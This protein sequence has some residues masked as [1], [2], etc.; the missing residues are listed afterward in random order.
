MECTALNASCFTLPVLRGPGSFGGAIPTNDLFETSFTNGQR[1]IFRQSFQKRWDASLVKNTAITERFNLKYT[2]DVYNLTNTASFDVPGNEVSQNE[3]Y[4]TFPFRASGLQCLALGL[5]HVLPNHRPGGLYYCPA[6]SDRH[7]H[8][9]KR[10][11]NPDVV[12]AHL[13]SRL[14]KCKRPGPKRR[15][16]RLSFVEEPVYAVTGHS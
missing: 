6:V 7:S 2:F 16:G 15:P 9:R 4:N 11:A 5:R 8:H 3:N 12:A 13:L 10:S 1:N 14:R